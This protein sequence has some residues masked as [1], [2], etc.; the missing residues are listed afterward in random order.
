MQT[1]FQ[2]ILLLKC[3]IHLFFTLTDSIEYQYGWTLGW[4]IVALF[5]MFPLLRLHFKHPLLTY[6]LFALVCIGFLWWFNVPVHL[7]VEKGEYYGVIGG[8]INV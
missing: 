6:L 4:S 5:I 3:S 1:L 8:S 7:P 2:I